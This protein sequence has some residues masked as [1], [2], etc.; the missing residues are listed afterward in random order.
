MAI[1][2]KVC[3]EI[4]SLNVMN[5]CNVRMDIIGDRTLELLWKSFE[6]KLFLKSSH[7]E[8]CNQVII[9]KR[10]V[11]LKFTYTRLHTHIVGA[12]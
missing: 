5:C 11:L 10:K 4:K 9:I 7:V 8:Y 6:L 3:L 2:I 12:L 1:V